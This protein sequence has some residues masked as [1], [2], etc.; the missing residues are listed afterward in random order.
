MDAENVVVELGEHAARLPLC[1]KHELHSASS[2]EKWKGAAHEWHVLA[3]G[4]L[5]VFPHGHLP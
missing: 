2:N 4:I 1:D 5:E 3:R